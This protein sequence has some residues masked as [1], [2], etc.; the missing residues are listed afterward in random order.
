MTVLFFEENVQNGVIGTFLGLKVNNYINLFIS[1]FEIVP[2]A[3]LS[4]VDK[5]D[6]FVFLRKILIMPK[7]R[8][9]VVLMSKGNT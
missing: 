8:E 7:M 4:K 9:M 6:S 5:G 1:I 3:K 2:D